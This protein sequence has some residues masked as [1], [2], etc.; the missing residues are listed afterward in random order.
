MEKKQK[1]KKNSN[2]ASYEPLQKPKILLQNFNLEQDGKYSEIQFIGM[3]ICTTPGDLKSIVN[4]SDDGKYVGLDTTKEDLQARKKSFI[5]AIIKVLQSNQINMSSNVLKIFAVPEFYSRGIAGAYLDQREPYQFFKDEFADLIKTFQTELYFKDWI[6]VLGTVL[7][8]KIPV[9]QNREPT[10][11][12][13]H[14]GDNLLDVYYRLHPNSTESKREKGKTLH[15][16][17][18][19]IDG[20]TVTNKKN[21]NSVEDTAFGDVLKSTLNYCDMTADIT[22]DNSCYIITGGTD[23]IIRV[24]KKNKSKEDFVLNSLNKTGEE[25]GYLQSITKY[26]PIFNEDEVKISD[27]DTRAIF[28][29]NGIWIG[30]DICLDHS[31]GRLVENLKKNRQQYVDIQ[32]ITSCGMQITDSAVAARTGGWVINCDGEYTLGNEKEAHDGNYSH[33][34]LRQVKIQINPDDKQPKATLNQNEKC[35]DIPCQA[36]TEIMPMKEYNLH[37]YPSVPL[38]NEK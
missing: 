16:M 4:T 15:R 6:F 14:T 32:I 2:E 33:T 34:S 36:S 31:R 11:S 24:L 26:A 12:L 19:E 25:N 35:I 28:C 20:R 27:D 23:R 22:V 10:K 3:S 1:S 29:H 37:I 13:Y 8:T 21:E 18:K 30:I 5:D 38:S 17:M 9:I 7:T